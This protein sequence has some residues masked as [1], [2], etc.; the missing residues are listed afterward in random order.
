MTRRHRNK[1]AA[2][3]DPVISVKSD[4]FKKIQRRVL[5]QPSQSTQETSTES[6]PSETPAE[7]TGYNKLVGEWAQIKNKLLAKYTK[8]DVNQLH[9]PRKEQVM[10]IDAVIYYLD[11][12]AVLDE[13]LTLSDEE[14]RNILLGG[15]KLLQKEVEEWYEQRITFGGMLA[16]PSNSCLYENIS[17]ILEGFDEPL[18]QQNLDKF[19]SFVIDNKL[20]T[21]SGK[22][23]EFYTIESLQKYYSPTQ[24]CCNERSS[25]FN[26]FSFGLFGAASGHQPD[27]K[28]ELTA[29]SPS[30]SNTHS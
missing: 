26:R 20:L 17:V 25:F 3:S 7:E 10:F 19:L 2:P 24:T 6:S 14:K 15:F 12:L 28:S 18:K 21:H 27:V 1:K 5:T 29:A 23:I 13:P 30:T 8:E 22:T 11:N 16:S 4:A 9:S